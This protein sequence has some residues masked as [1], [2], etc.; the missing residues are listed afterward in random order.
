MDQSPNVPGITC[1]ARHPEGSSSTPPTSFI[2]PENTESQLI[3]HLT[4]TMKKMS[5]GTSQWLSATKKSTSE[6]NLEISRSTTIDNIS[7][8]TNISETSLSHLLNPTT[9]STGVTVSHS[10]SNVALPSFPTMHSSIPS[11]IGRT[12]NSPCSPPDLYIELEKVTSQVIQFHWKP[13][14]RESPYN[15][16]LMAD[17][18]ILNKT[19]TNSTSMKF[20]NLS[21]GHQYTISVKVLSCSEMVTSSVTVQTDPAPCFNRSDFCSQSTKCLDSQYYICSSKQAF[22]CN[23]LFKS[24]TF[25]SDLYSP[26]SENY[27]NLSVRIKKTITEGMK[28]RLRDDR[29][30]VI[31]IGFQP[32]SVIAYFAFLLQEQQFIEARNLEADLTAVVKNMLDNQTE[33]TVKAIPIPEPKKEDSSWKTAVIV[34]AVLFCVALIFILLLLSVW[35]Y[36]KRRTGKYNVE[37]QGL[38]GNF[39]YKYL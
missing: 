4:T 12:T 24:W 27:K 35:L 1:Q 30:D 18:T 31:M 38:M 3:S 2:P 16:S 23:V 14:K 22:A 32:G 25:Q 17:N 6:M 8:V 39:A 29:F 15:V 10:E 7:S 33:V 13:L 11:T 5:S 37:P 36:M 20:E 21:P 19:V 34:L 28:I 26:E 9:S